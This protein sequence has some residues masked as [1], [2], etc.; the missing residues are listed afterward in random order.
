M[1]VFQRVVSFS[2]RCGDLLIV[3]HE[4]QNHDEGH[5]SCL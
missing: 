1:P 5:W 3:V 4:F 2:S